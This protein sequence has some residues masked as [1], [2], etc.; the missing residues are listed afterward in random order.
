VY[1][2]DEEFLE[3]TVPFLGEGLALDQSLLAVATSRLTDLLR[4]ALGDRA[5]GVDFADAEDW[6]DSPNGA[7]T[8]YRN[9]FDEKLEAG[10]TWIRVVGQPDWKCETAAEITTWTRYESMVNLVCAP[11]PVTF[12]CAYDVR[13]LPAKLIADAR[14]T[15]PKLVDGVDTTTSPAYASPEDFLI[16]S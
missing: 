14:R 9:Y 4:Q 6:Y 3:T 5:R 13:S 16:Q 1:E 10:V 11:W 8:R 7:L 15:H 12:I 2:S